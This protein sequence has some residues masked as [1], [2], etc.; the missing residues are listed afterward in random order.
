MVGASLC[1][2]ISQLLGRKLVQLYFPARAQQWAEQVEKHRDNLFNY[3]VFLRVT[4]FLPNW[5]I[6]LTA[7]VIGVPLAP[8]AFGTFVGVAPPSFIA[9]QGGQTL[10]TMTEQDS[11]F[12]IT[13]FVWLAIFGFV[14][15]V[16]IFL[17][18]RF[19]NKIE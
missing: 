3:M 13:S 6:N 16:P 7:P 19:K 18:D 1:F 11:A 8:F 5:F 15:L 2:L 14:A 4:P 10:H 9:I 12:S 17:K